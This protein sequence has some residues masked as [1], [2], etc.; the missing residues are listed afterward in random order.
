MLSQSEYEKKYKGLQHLYYNKQFFIDIAIKYNY[1]IVPVYIERLPDSKFEMTIHKPFE[2]EKTGS[3]ETDI[4]N[5]TLK[6]NK[7]IEKMIL[8]KPE[9]WI[10]LHNRWKILKYVGD[11]L[12][13]NIE[14][15]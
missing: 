10:W 9:Q 11:T 12:E 5:L 7:E 14:N 8:N 4:Y 6:I 1:K 13:L 2:Y 15:Y 3:H